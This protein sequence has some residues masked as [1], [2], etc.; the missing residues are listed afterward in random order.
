[1]FW[2]RL[3]RPGVG[4]NPAFHN[5]MLSRNAP[6]KSQWA[7]STTMCWPFDGEGGFGDFA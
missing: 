2:V 3:E 4:S 7:L 5:A 6:C 1:M